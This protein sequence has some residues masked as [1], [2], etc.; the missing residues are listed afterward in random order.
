MEFKITSYSTALFSSWVFLDELGLLFDA[1][2]GIMS[3]LL[4]KSRKIKQ[5][6]ISHADRDHLSGLP[7]FCQLNAREGLPKIHYPSDSGSFPAMKAFLE[8]FDPHVKGIEWIPIQEKMEFKVKG[9]VFVE[10]IRN[11]HIQVEDHLNKSL[12][13]KVSERKRKIKDEFI[14][15]SGKE[16]AAISRDKGKNFLTRE[17]RSVLF[18][19]SG[20]TPVEDYNRWDGTKVL[21]HESTFLTREDGK[22]NDANKHSNLEDVME[23][24]AS[25]QV[26]KLILNHFSSRYSHKE[27]DQAILANC[28]RY[29]INIPV[30]RI[31]PG[32]V[33]RD[34]LR[35]NPVNMTE[36]V[37]NTFAEKQK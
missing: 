8:K 9:N 29:D 20:D 1:G 6:F 10:S 5:V 15:L 31:L 36:S 28:K 25:I 12:S 4:Q 13:Y 23:M 2:D 37:K 14:Q 30:Y 7:Q 18:G 17:E 11:G 32:R 22:R 3:S 19:Y 33:H 24:V 21:M 35:E 34:I 27:I 16:I 26:K